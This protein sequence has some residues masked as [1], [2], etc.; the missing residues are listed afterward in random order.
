ML[1]V[2]YDTIDTVGCV[3]RGIKMI[4]AEVLNALGPNGMLIN[5]SR[6]T[7]VDEDALVAALQDGRLGYAGLD[8]FENEPAVPEALL[9]MKN[10]VLLP[11][12]GSGT[13]ETRAAM[14]SL[15]ADN[16]MQFLEDGTLLTPVPE[17]AHM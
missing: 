5:V 11:H 3:Q 6:G 13:V 4:N 1:G 9:S 15:A 16:L 10:V 14:G 8:V 7:V 12:V 2:S 17:C